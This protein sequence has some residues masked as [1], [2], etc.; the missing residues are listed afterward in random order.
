MS[1]QETKE[2]SK[3]LGDKMIQKEEKD[4]IFYQV[5]Q[6]IVIADMSSVNPEE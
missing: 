2:L 6:M 5:G 4:D 3:K 1:T